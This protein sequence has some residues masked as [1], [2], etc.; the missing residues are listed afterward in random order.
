MAVLPR[1]V[2]VVARVVGAAVVTH[3]AI[4]VDM[5]H[6]GMAWLVGVVAVLM[7][8]WCAVFLWWCGMLWW[9]CAVLL[10]RAVIRLGS[11][12][13]RGVLLMRTGW[14]AAMGFGWM[15]RVHRKGQNG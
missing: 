8:L 11:A 12:G 6:I 5:G 3:P 7:L 14:R 9:W 4:V 13:G 2:E 15:L 10:W 1:V